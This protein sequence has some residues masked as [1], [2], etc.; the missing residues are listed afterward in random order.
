MAAAV[1]TACTK[2]VFSKKV[3]PWGNPGPYCFM[4]LFEGVFWKNGLLGVV[5]CGD[6]VVDGVVRRGGLMVVFRS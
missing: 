5:F 2:K 4:G 3:R 6:L 1:W